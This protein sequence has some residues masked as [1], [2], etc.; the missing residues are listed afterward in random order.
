GE[1]SPDARAAATTTSVERQDNTVVVARAQSMWSPPLPEEPVEFT[2]VLPAHLQLPES[3][4]SAALD[5]AQY[6]QQVARL[7]TPPARRADAPVVRNSPAYRARLVE[8]IRIREGLDF[9][10]RKRTTLEEAEQMYGVP[11][12]VI[13]AIIGVETVYGRNT[14][15]F[16]V[17]DALYTLAFSYPQGARRDRSPYFREELGEY[18]AMTLRNGIDPRSIRGSYAGAIGIPQFMP[19][20]IRRYAVG[21]TNR[22]EPDL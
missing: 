3:Q 4:V 11:A 22:D 6:N 1:K 17:L 9:W 16:P 12:S 20:S 2:R 13:V 10:R 21:A 7:M 5:Q 15:N 8:A 19:G 14:G 18:L